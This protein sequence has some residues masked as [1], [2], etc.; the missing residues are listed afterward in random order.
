LPPAPGEAP[1]P[2]ADEPP[3]DFRT[4]AAPG[5]LRM[6]DLDPPT[7]VSFVLAIL[8]VYIAVISR[9]KNPS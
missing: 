9:E 5:D 2:P 8:F 3:L 1:L 6:G 4:A 7:I